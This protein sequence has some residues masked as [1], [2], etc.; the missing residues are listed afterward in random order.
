[1]GLLPT[2]PALQAPSYTKENQA[3]RMRELAPMVVLTCAPKNERGTSLDGSG[4]GT[5]VP[6][7]NSQA[8]SE[9]ESV[10]EA[11][12]S[13]EL[14][15]DAA[16]LEAV[17]LDS[18]RKS[19]A[20]RSGRTIAPALSRFAVAKLHHESAMGRS[21][22]FERTVL[23]KRRPI[24]QGSEYC[25]SGSIGTDAGI[26]RRFRGGSAPFLLRLGGH[27]QI[28]DTA[29]GRTATSGKGRASSTV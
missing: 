5:S 14:D 25:V 7:H 23:S 19:A 2:A 22:S 10:L 21:A 13:L 18:R 27:N 3:D 12:S 29:S 11:D 28:G 26:P 1:M 20:I 4:S 6:G 16:S 15:V 17:P 9:S 8:G 24:A